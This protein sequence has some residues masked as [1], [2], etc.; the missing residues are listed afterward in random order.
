MRKA[1]RRLAQLYDNVLVPCGLKSTQFSILVELARRADAPPTMN[2]LADELVMDRSTLGHNLR[3]LERDG[4]LALEEG[5]TDRR[6]R[7]VVLTSQGKAKCAEARELRRSAGCDTA[8][9]AARHRLRRAPRGTAR[10]VTSFIASSH[11][12]HSPK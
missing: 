8:H 12:T 6:R 9:H 5:K 2:E 7:H 4:L 10:R 1:S 11:S 3:P